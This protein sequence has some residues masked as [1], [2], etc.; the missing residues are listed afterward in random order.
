MVDE[1]EI[2]AGI[3][4]Y[5]AYEASSLGRIASLYKLNPRTGHTIGTTRRILKVRPMKNGYLIVNLCVNKEKAKN[6]LVHHLVL[7]AFGKP[8]PPGMECRHLDGNRTNN[9][10]ENLCW[11]TRQEN[12]QDRTRHGKTVR[13]S[14]HGMARLI[15]EDI[16]EIRLLRETEAKSTLELAQMFGISR[17][18]TD[19]IIARR[20]WK[21]V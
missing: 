16:R 17:Q 6:K 20:R 15:A 4:D 5:P 21:H 2:W 18:H 9:R 1:I 7:T 11:G 10:L 19:D 8:Q 3:P 12:I 14:E 13:G